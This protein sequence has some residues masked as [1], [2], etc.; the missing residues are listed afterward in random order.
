MYIEA[1]CQFFSVALYLI[2]EKIL[3]L[4]LELIDWLNWLT[5]EPKGSSYFPASNSRVTDVD[6]H[7]WLL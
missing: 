4:N 7:G 5:D 6:H 1:R 3:L 2:L